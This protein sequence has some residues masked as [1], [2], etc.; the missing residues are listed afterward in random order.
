MS[1][2][3][4]GKLLLCD[5]PGCVAHVDAPVTLGNI[6]AI[7]RG[8][9]WLCVQRNGLSRHFC[10]DHAG[11]VLLDGDPLAQDRTESILSRDIV[12]I[13]DSSPGA[14][15]ALGQAVELLARQNGANVIVLFVAC[16]RC[17]P[18]RESVPT[19]MVLEQFSTDGYC[20]GTRK[21]L[22]NISEILASR[23][24]AYRLEV[25]TGGSVASAIIRRAEQKSHEIIMVAASLAESA[26][27]DLSVPVLVI[28]DA[29]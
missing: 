23:S 25:Q 8:Q 4:D 11:S 13:M 19:G 12:L 20:P 9:R 24:V 29:G 28:P 18:T 27:L 26:L 1:R 21:A 5:A 22:K 3:F 2:S 10:Q 15:A 14:N 17:V 6:S 7:D 16:G